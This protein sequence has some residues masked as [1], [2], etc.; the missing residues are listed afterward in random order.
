M[1]D[2]QRVFYVFKTGKAT[3]CLSLSG[4]LIKNT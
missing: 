3:V 2:L 4:H 1:R